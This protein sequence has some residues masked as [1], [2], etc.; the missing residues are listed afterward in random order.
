MMRRV[1][2]CFLFV[3]VAGMCLL[4]GCRSK[5]SAGE[6]EAASVDVRDIDFGEAVAPNFTNELGGRDPL[7]GFNRS[8]LHVNKFGHRYVVRPVTGFWGS[9]FPRHIVGCF[10]RFTENIGFPKRMFSSFLQA[11][12]KGGGI[13]FLRFLT[14]TTVG[15][16]G[17]Y[18]PAG[19]W[20]D[21]EVQDE[22]FGQA[23]ASWGI[24]PGAYLHLP[25]AGPT[26]IR[27]GVGLIFDAAFDPKTYF[28]GGQAFTALNKMTS[29]YREV[30]TFMRSTADPYELSK[31]LYN[32]ER[33]IKINNYDKRDKIRAEQEL[34]DE[35]YAKIIAASPVEVQAD[36]GNTLE[37]ITVPGFNSQGTAVDTLRVAQFDIINDR[38]SMWVDV[39]LWNSDFYN[40][41]SERSVKVI[42]DKSA[43][44]YKVWFQKDN[45]HA[46]LA[47]VLPGTGSHYSGA[48]LNALA[49]IFYNQGFTV[50]ALSSS[51]NWQFMETAASVLVPGYIPQDAG[52][53][54]N[55]ISKVIEDLEQNRGCSFPAKVLAGYSMG[56]IQS[57]FMAEQ[58]QGLCPTLRIGFDRYIAINPPV[59]LL[60]AVREI[61]KFALAWK[62]W[63]RDEVFHHA[64]FAAGKF[65]RMSRRKHEPFA[66]PACGSDELLRQSVD[67]PFNPIEAEV[68]IGYSFKI[69]LQEVILSIHRKRDFG[70]LKAPY[71]WG[72]RADFYREI[73]QFTFM[74]YVETFLLKYYSDLENR[75]LTMDELAARCD[76]RNKTESLKSMNNIYVLHTL[77]D[78][79]VS[80]AERQWLVDTFS[81]RCV[82]FQYGGHLGEFYFMLFREEIAAR[83]RPVVE[84]AEE[85][86]RKMNVPVA[87]APQK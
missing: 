19:A 60:G 6:N 9:I 8:M 71:S 63:E 72:N 70:F 54:R 21:L 74:R 16:A 47:V 85:R 10:N 56:G 59:D 57:I 77:D 50:V 2:V 78:F 7:E 64:A 32:V 75:E 86:L 62:Q 51:F 23:F 79:I 15:I 58:E 24:G 22:D 17:F 11:E 13:V 18:D 68:L 67:L 83:A 26:N 25:V 14:N 87:V 31:R 44:P 46:P 61:D 36:N 12:F 35:E 33:Y 40:A 69:S 73:E 53:M 38:E 55:A 76:M 52:D 4:C 30:D 37:Y 80:N 66:A 39:S 29:S 1:Y 65:M 34:I 28:Y 45:K 48:E 81:G 42:E 20:F 82:F 3:S 5:D 43:M 41:A 84:L 49:E 27:D